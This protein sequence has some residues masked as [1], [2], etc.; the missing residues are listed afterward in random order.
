MEDDFNII[1]TF[2]SKSILAFLLSEKIKYKTFDTQDTVDYI[3]ED[4]LKRVEEEGKEEVCF[5]FIS[6]DDYKNL[7]REYKR[8]KENND[9]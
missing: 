9:E 5:G 2:N 1:S 3:I 6:K 7:I 8:R 4:I